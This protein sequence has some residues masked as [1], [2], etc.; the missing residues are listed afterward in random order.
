MHVI[1][2]TGVFIKRAMPRRPARITGDEVTPQSHQQPCSLG[3]GG[4]GAEPGSTYACYMLPARWRCGANRTPAL[5][6]GAPRNKQDDGTF[7]AVGN[8][9]NTQ[10]CFDQTGEFRIS[11]SLKLAVGGKC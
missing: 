8:S 4:G 9:K 2:C 10:T 7:K 6:D 11:I 3:G 1:R 5:I